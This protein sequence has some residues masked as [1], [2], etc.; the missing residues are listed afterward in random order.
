MTKE[1]ALKIVSGEFTPTEEEEKQA[2]NLLAI[3]QE[4]LR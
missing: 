3:V 2:E 1:D 4:S